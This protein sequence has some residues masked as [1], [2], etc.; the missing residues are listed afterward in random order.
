MRP[1]LDSP[2]AAVDRMKMFI[3]EKFA[4][5]GLPCPVTGQSGAV[6]QQALGSGAGAVQQQAAQPS[7]SSS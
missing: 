2:A 6:G 3:Y 4:R 1:A 5:Y 7:T